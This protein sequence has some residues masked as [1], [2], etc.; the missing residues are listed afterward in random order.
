MA[1]KIILAEDSAFFV[2]TIDVPSVLSDSD[3]RDFL[4]AWIENSSP[5]PV[6]KIRFGFVR[7]GNTTTVFAGAEERLYANFDSIELGAAD[8]FI[9]PIS[10][11][12][13]GEFSDGVYFL[14]SG[15]S[16]SR[17]ELSEGGVK[18]FSSCQI[19]DDIIVDIRLLRADN[20]AEQ[21]RF[22]RLK[23]VVSN[24]KITANF[25]ECKESEFVSGDENESSIFSVQIQKKRLSLADVRDVEILKRMSRERRK[26]ELRAIFIKSIPVVF[27]LLFVSQIFL[28]FKG[29]R[30]DTL[31]NDYAEIAPKAKAV[32]SNSEKLAELKMFSEKR[33]HS[34]SELAMLSVARPDGIKFV[35]FEQTSPFDIKLR[36]SAKSAGSVYSFVRALKNLD[37]V[38]SV[39]PDIEI[40]RGEAKYTIILK[41]K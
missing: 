18:S 33:L 6:E 30:V 24:G 38:K 3:A 27:L 11:L 2:K 25:L 13:L 5:L 4:S 15:N 31:E 28:W 14:K 9:S 35:R 39:E 7:N 22:L 41:L 36:G 21:E 17:V 29:V 12:L 40:A 34:I 16:I 26:S 32:E 19:S 20:V 1:E 23:D 37:S 8:F 10:L